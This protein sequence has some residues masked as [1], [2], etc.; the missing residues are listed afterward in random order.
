MWERR[1][2][3]CFH[4]RKRYALFSS[5]HPSTHTVVRYNVL[6]WFCFVL[7]TKVQCAQYAMYGST[8]KHRY[9]LTFVR[10]VLC[11][12]N[13]IAHS[14][15]SFSETT[16]V[17]KKWGSH[18]QTICY[19]IGLVAVSV[20]VSCIWRSFSSF[21]SVDVAFVGLIVIY[22]LQQSKSTAAIT[23]YYSIHWIPY[24]VF[25]SFFALWQHFFDHFCLMRK[26]IFILSI[27]SI[28]RVI[29]CILVGVLFINS[30]VICFN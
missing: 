17:S 2:H 13:A 26:P 27:S 6:F 10:L 30:D 28:S 5:I 3:F 12:C 24:S 8:L 1:G 9:S 16:N 20:S 18:S 19:W 25:K 29:A 15:C 23:Q 7:T 21:E 14:L 22:Y 11:V 4:F